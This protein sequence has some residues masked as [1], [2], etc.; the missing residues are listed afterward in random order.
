MK[1]EQLQFDFHHIVLP[2]SHYHYDRFDT[3]NDEIEGKWSVNYLTNPQGDIDKI[4]MSVDEGEVTFTRKADASMSD[5]AILA[6]YLGEYE[7]AGTITKVVLKDDNKLVLTIPGQPN[8]ELLPYKKDKFRFKQFADLLVTFIK[9]N[10][11]IK[12]FELTD[13]SGVY[14]YNKR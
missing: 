5:P 11:V 4:V 10:G 14:K 8:Y 3:P 9:E 6:K 2:L 12:A 1:D 7:L 13:P